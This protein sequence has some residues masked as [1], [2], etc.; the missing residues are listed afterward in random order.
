MNR[1][2]IMHRE[3]MEKETKENIRLRDGRENEIM[4]YRRIAHEKMMELPFYL[5]GG[6]K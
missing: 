5:K 1:G 6:K 4:R 3:Q 2:Q